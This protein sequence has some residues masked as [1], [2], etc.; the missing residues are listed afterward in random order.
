MARKHKGPL[1]GRVDL[2]RQ[3][4]ERAGGRAGGQEMQIEPPF[5]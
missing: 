5:P 4:A 1:I 2:G 3:V